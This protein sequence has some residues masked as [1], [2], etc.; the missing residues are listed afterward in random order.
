MRNDAVGKK[1]MITN[2]AA[3][4]YIRDLSLQRVG[5]V[6]NPSAATP[7]MTS[8]R[9]RLANRTTQPFI[10]CMAVIRGMTLWEDTGAD[11]SLSYPIS[12]LM[13][14][15]QKPEQRS[16]LMRRS[17]LPHLSARKFFQLLMMK[18]VLAK[19]QE[20]TGLAQVYGSIRSVRADRPFRRVRGQFVCVHIVAMKDGNRGRRQ[21]HGQHGGLPVRKH[22]FISS[23]EHHP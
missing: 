20:I 21:G 13:P 10:S 16:V 18:V 1:A 2:G 11:I 22:I 7:Q 6:N 14:A 4:I 3:A 19:L 5:R 12:G 23:P 17:V 8:R 15:E 9:I